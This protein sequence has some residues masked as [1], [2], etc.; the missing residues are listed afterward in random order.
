MELFA[1]NFNNRHFLTQIDARVKII[2]ALVALIL[3]L[4]YKG[5]LFPLIVILLCTLLCRIMM[6]PTKV[7]LMRYSEPVFIVL[8]LMILKCFFYGS[9]PLFQIELQIFTLKGNKEGLIEGLLLGVRIIASVSIIIALS[10]STSFTEIIAGL[11][12]FRIPKTLIEITMFA[13]R[14]IF[15]LMEDAIVIYNAQKNRLGYSSMKRGL[16]S[17]S[18][19]TCSLIIKAFDHSQKTTVSMIQRGYDGNI[20]LLSQKPFKPNEIIASVLFLTTLGIIWKI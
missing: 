13:Y 1:E 9:E 18:T 5:F 12:W 10:F 14:Y 17:F 15:I 2:V 19:L 16:N 8:V 3:V 7:F 4:S 6:V 20:P 11:S